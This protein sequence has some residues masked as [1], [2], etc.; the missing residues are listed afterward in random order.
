MEYDDDSCPICHQLLDDPASTE[1]GHTACVACL[2]TWI[3]A[4]K[5]DPQPLGTHFKIPARPR[6]D[7]LLFTCPLCRAETRASLDD[8]RRRQL[9]EQG[10]QQDIDPDTDMFQSV[11][12]FYTCQVKKL[13]RRFILYCSLGYLES[14]W[15]VTSDY[16]MRRHL[17]I[18]LS[19]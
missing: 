11:R 17:Y 10:R 19:G 18:S 14:L 7:D 8:T 3:A 13:V 16:H 1:C 4:S 2:L 5:P 6:V 12:R 15:L 9:Q